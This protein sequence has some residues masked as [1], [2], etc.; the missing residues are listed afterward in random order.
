MGSLRIFDQV[1]AYGQGNVVAAEE[2]RAMIGV[3]TGAQN[4]S[5]GV[6]TTTSTFAPRIEGDPFIRPFI[7][8][9]L[10]LKPRDKLLPWLEQ[11]STSA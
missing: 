6:V 8:Y 1:K 9:R 3:I 7:P 11:L 5:K 4:V 10:E 2:V